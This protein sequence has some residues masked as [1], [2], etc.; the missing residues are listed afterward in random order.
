MVQNLKEASWFW[1]LNHHSAEID[2]IILFEYLC[3]PAVWHNYNSAF[4]KL[5]SYE[6]QYAERKYGT[7]LIKENKATSKI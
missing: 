6:H 1:F 3:L 7:T 2:Y 5:T 4:Q